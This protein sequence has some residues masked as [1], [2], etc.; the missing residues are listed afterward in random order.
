M[1]KFWHVSVKRW[2]HAIFKAAA[3]SAFGLKD[4]GDV[5][6]GRHLNGLI[7]C[8]PLSSLASLGGKHGKFCEFSAYY[9][10]NRSL[11]VLCWEPEEGRFHG[12]SSGNQKRNDVNT[13]G[14][15]CG[16]LKQKHT[17]G[18]NERFPG[19]DRQEGWSG[20]QG[21]QK[22]TERDPNLGAREEQEHS[23]AECEARWHQHQPASSVRRSQTR[24]ARGTDG[25]R[26]WET[27]AWFLALNTFLLSA[28]THPLTLLSANL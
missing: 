12:W 10:S 2:K 26:P 19:R 16:Y 27:E 8:P 13:V 3:V 23:Q 15:W 17:E 9:W 25:Q 24:F 28:T 5:C 4:K 20:E 7:S 1:L 14:N 22:D 18:E 11:L 6:W 21:T